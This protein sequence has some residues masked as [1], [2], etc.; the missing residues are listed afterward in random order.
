MCI[1]DLSLLHLKRASEPPLNK[2]TPEHQGTAD[3]MRSECVKLV[4]CLRRVHVLREALVCS[5]FLSGGGGGGGGGGEL[6]P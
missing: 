1:I 2:W 3:F 6:P 4:Q 5:G